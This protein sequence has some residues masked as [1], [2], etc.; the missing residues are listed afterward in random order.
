[1]GTLYVNMKP[2]CESGN[3]DAHEAMTTTAVKANSAILTSSGYGVIE[4]FSDEAHL[5]HVGV[6]PDA[7]SAK[8]FYVFP[9]FPMKINCGVNCKVSAKALA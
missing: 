8:A 3:A 4:L 5:V 7:D 1:M 6:A 2:D 9:G